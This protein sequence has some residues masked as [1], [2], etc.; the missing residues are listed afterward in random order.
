MKRAGLKLVRTGS[1]L[2]VFALVSACGVA[3]AE[4][5]TDADQSGKKVWGIG[6]GQAPDQ[7]DQPGVGDKGP[8]GKGAQSPWSQFGVHVPT[9]DG[10][11][12]NEAGL[13]TLEFSHPQL[14]GGIVVYYG[15]ALNEQAIT[16]ALSGPVPL[17]EQVV[18]Q[19]EGQ[20]ESLSQGGGKRPYGAGQ[21]K[22]MLAGIPRPQTDRGDLGGVAVLA[23]GKDQAGLEQHLAAFEAILAGITFGE[24]QE[25]A[26]AK[27]F[28]ARGTWKHESSESSGDANV[29]VVS[30]SLYY[31]QFCG[32]QYS[33]EDRGYV[34]GTVGGG[35]ASYDD[36]DRR[37]G[38]Y[39]VFGSDK[40]A[41]VVTTDEQGQDVRQV[42]IDLSP[43]T[44]T[45][46]IGD[47]RYELVKACQ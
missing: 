38:R 28:L 2:A 5:T 46:K 37:A 7:G 47:T 36:T 11:K 9:P 42:Q 44:D 45:F 41:I 1:T 24:I 12:L 19:P 20:I 22:G 18:L 43:T 13:D 8:A 32:D 35:G 40:T 21:A 6:Q 34:G 14:D 15:F 4:P 39:F 27:Q 23:L 25:Y 3:P 30:I 16:Q 29:S 31:Y 17:S 26:A 33:F 10:Y